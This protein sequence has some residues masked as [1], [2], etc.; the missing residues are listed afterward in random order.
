MAVGRWSA[1][2]DSMWSRKCS[3]CPVHIKKGDICFYD[4]G[5]IKCRF[6]SPEAAEEY[7]LQKEHPTLPVLGSGRPWYEVDMGMKKGVE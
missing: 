3:T 2:V 7:R 1:V 4:W 5:V 6:C